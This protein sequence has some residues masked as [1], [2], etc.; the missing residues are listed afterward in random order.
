M[1]LYTTFLSKRQKTLQS[2]I[3]GSIFI[4]ALIAA[5]VFK[6]IG[7]E[8]FSRFVRGF[9]IGLMAALDGALIHMLLKCRSAVKDEE[10]LKRMYFEAYDER[11]KLLH[12]KSGGSALY[13]C[14]L[15]L[16]APAVASACFR[17][18]AFWAFVGCSALLLITR[19]V[20]LIYYSKQLYFNTFS[21][22]ADSSALVLEPGCL[23]CRLISCFSRK[24]P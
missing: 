16:L 1:E 3:I 18:D 2:A 21:V 13:L 14:S 19:K 11:K 20:L 23:R 15:A 6:P 22:L 5:S 4:W 17:P 8:N 7:L 9:Q 10:K 24:S 12:E